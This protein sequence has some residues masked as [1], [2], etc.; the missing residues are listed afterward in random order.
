LN[1]RFE[2]CFFEFTFLDL[3]C[4]VH[5][6]NESLDGAT[7]IATLNEE[8]E[9]AVLKLRKGFLVGPNAMEAATKTGRQCA[10]W[11]R[12]IAP[13]EQDSFAQTVANQKPSRLIREDVP[14][15]FATEKNRAVLLDTCVR[16]QQ[17]LGD[18][19]QAMCF[20]AAYF[21]LLMRRERAFALT[22]TLGRNDRWVGSRWWDRV[23]FGTEAFAFVELLALHDP[24]VHA[25][26]A[27]LTVLPEAYTQRWFLALCVDVLPYANLLHVMELFLQHGVVV[28]H[29]VGLA[30]V[31]TQ[32][33]AMLA[34]TQTGQ[35][36]ALLSQPK[37]EHGDEIVRLAGLEETLS[38]TQLLEMRV[39]VGVKYQ[40]RL[41][42]AA[43]QDSTRKHTGETDSDDDNDDDDDDSDAFECLVCHDNMPEVLCDQCGGLLLCEKCHKKGKGQGHSKDHAVKSVEGMDFDVLQKIA[44]EW[45]KK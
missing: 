17:R 4:F 36:I 23:S 40:H 33:K 35:C 3:I 5:T 11:S 18:Y 8:K 45:R 16:L 42:S 37:E 28:M 12:F 32:R 1:T 34:C 9:G 15:T 26:L 25:H 30:I 41:V 13:V 27:R 2:L 43:G 24:E 44:N 20:V 10:A 6:Q 38:V 31:S 14:R 29:R 19:S 21:S 22:V 39:A 7:I